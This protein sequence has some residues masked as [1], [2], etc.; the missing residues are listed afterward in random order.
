MLYCPC[1]NFPFWVTPASVA[2]A[3]NLSPEA[4]LAPAVAKTRKQR[5]SPRA[6]PTA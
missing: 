5:Q 4:P 6:K 1:R 2:A 3:C